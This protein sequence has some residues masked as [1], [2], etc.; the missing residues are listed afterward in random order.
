MK[1][2]F[3]SNR[4]QKSISLSLVTILL[5][6][7]LLQQCGAEEQRVT[8][9]RGTNSDTN[10]KHD[11]KESAYDSSTEPLKL[12]SELSQNLQE[13]GL[14]QGVALRISD[15]AVKGLKS[16]DHNGLFPGFLSLFVTPI[17]R[18]LAG[19]VFGAI[20]GAVQNVAPG[21]AWGGIVGG[22]LRTVANVVF[23]GSPL[24][25]DNHWAQNM[26]QMV[27]AQLLKLKKSGLLNPNPPAN[28]QA[29]FLKESLFPVLKKCFEKR[30]SELFGKVLMEFLQMN[31]KNKNWS[32][33]QRNEFKKMGLKIFLNAILNYNPLDLTLKENLIKDIFSKWLQLEMNL[34]HD[35]QVN[36]E[37]WMKEMKAKV[38]TWIPEFNSDILVQ[39]KWLL[40]LDETRLSE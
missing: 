40:I 16:E 24:Q 1:H 31:G 30:N 22:L 12:H 5:S 2:A 9:N 4:Q 7:P 33:E 36:Q 6:A 25:Q 20:E 32:D 3:F 26:G 23:K 19:F 39:K 11:S 18:Q 17:L 35:S 15:Q 38:A 27:F 13:F 21:K 10:V 29:D 28:P 8:V 34:K 14:T 37:K